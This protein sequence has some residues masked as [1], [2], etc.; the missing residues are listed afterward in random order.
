MNNLTGHIS[1]ETFLSLS[2]R[3]LIQKLRGGKRAEIIY[4]YWSASSP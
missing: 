2:R 4:S 3:R 1:Y